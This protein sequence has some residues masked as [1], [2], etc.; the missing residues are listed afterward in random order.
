MSALL[1]TLKNKRKQK[2]IFAKFFAIDILRMQRSL[3]FKKKKILTFPIFDKN[4][5]G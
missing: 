5:E 4:I 2:K 1:K 3:L